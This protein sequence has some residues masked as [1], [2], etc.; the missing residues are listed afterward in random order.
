MHIIDKLLHNFSTKASSMH[1][2]TECNFNDIL[3]QLPSL[4]KIQNDS[5]TTSS[6]NNK[7]YSKQSSKKDEDPLIILAIGIPQNGKIYFEQQTEELTELLSDSKKHENTPIELNDSDVHHSN[8][9]LEIDE[10]SQFLLLNKTVNTKV[11]LEDIILDFYKKNALSF[12]ENE[13]DLDEAKS[14]IIS[15]QSYAEGDFWNIETNDKK[16]NNRC[17]NINLLE[18]SKQSP[19]LSNMITHN[20][21][22]TNLTKL[23]KP[24]ADI[25]DH[26][27]Q[28]CNEIEFKN[29]TTTYNLGTS[30]KQQQIIQLNYSN[31]QEFSKIYDIKNYL[32]NTELLAKYTKNIKNHYT[33]N[34]DTTPY[35]I[36]YQ[37]MDSKFKNILDCIGKYCTETPIINSNY[38]VA[39]SKI[40][41]HIIT[42]ELG[43]IDVEMDLAMLNNTYFTKNINITVEEPSTLK[44]LKQS[45]N[46]L[47]D[48]LNQDKKEIYETS[49]N[50]NLKDNLGSNNDTGYNNQNSKKYGINATSSSINKN[51]NNEIPI[52]NYD[53]DYVYG[54]IHLDIL[55]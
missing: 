31:Y 55:V 46:I 20:N 37:N 30:I 29:S 21:N 9:F 23:I 24:N 49:L 44:Y 50:L 54:T 35:S 33:N 26:K 38:N 15:I 22:E 52:S 8:K 16:I 27:T 25:L 14:D 53:K 4:E 32:N 41:I 18:N 47:S 45:I 36:N 13:L 6:L 34:L 19:S 43:K 11:E 12:T 48:A 51:K 40:I 28:F 1:C 17:I 42:Q 39:K 7:Q 2:D 5:T 10:N 3:N